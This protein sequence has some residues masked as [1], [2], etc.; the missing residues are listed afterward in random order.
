VLDVRAGLLLPASAGTNNI[1]VIL[2]ADFV[3][4]GK[5]EPRERPMHSAGVRSCGG[6]AW[7]PGLAVFARRGIPAPAQVPIPQTIRPEEKRAFARVGPLTKES[8]YSVYG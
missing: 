5:T 2:N 3:L 7:A 8:T 4:L 1:D 6:G